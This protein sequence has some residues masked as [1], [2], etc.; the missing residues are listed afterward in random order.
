MGEAHGFVP[1]CHPCVQNYSNLGDVC[2]CCIRI[3]DTAMWL[4]RVF[5]LL[6]HGSCMLL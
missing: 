3:P 4:A 6:S 1:T 2:V 5:Y